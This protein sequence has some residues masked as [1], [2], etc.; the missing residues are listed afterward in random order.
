[1]KRFDTKCRTNVVD[2]VLD[3]FKNISP[4]HIRKYKDKPNKGKGIQYF[5]CEG[6]GHMKAEC[7][8]FLKKQK[9]GMSITWSDSDDESKKK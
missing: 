9:K 4:Q 2:K 3:N 6:F 7:P 8:T 5:E 1:M